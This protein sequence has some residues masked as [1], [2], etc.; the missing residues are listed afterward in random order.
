ML[1]PFFSKKPSCKNFVSIFVQWISYY[2]PRAQTKT[3][4]PSLAVVKH[5]GIVIVLIYT[6]AVSHALR[7]QLSRFATY[8]TD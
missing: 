8:A 1:A 4:E 3:N 6:L 7:F 5:G 2:F